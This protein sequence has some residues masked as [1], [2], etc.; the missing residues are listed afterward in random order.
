MRTLATYIRTAF[1]LR[2]AL[3]VLLCAS[4]V[5]AETPKLN[6][7]LVHDSPLEHRAQE[8][9]LRLAAQYDLKKYTLTRDI[10]IEQGAVAHSSPVLTMNARFLP[11]PDAAPDQQQAAEDLMLS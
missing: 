10:N 9:L 8:Q 5:I 1:A 6:I 2:L 4:S 3:L 11:R 7:K